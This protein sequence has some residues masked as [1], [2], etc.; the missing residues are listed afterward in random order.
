MRRERASDGVGGVDGEVLAND[1]A[2]VVLA[3]DSRCKSHVTLDTGRVREARTRIANGPTA[4]AELRFALPR[5]SAERVASRHHAGQ[6]ARQHPGKV[7][8]PRS[9]WLIRR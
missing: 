7:R 2:N 9:R 5:R 8:A 1:A 6:S 3:K 4:R